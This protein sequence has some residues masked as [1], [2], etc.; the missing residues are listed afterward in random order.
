M[1]LPRPSDGWSVPQCDGDCR[2]KGLSWWGHSEIRPRAKLDNG[3]LVSSNSCMFPSGE[4][5]KA[6]TTNTI[7]EHCHLNYY[8]RNQTKS[9]SCLRILA[10][11][12]IG[13]CSFAKSYRGLLK[14]DPEETRRLSTDITHRLVPHNITSQ[15]LV[16]A[17]CAVIWTFIL[18]N[19]VK[20]SRYQLTLHHRNKRTLGLKAEGIVYTGKST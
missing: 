15:G 19:C 8:L 17:G 11:F 4:H 14:K 10:S 2:V 5:I 18:S 6:T 3:T 1:D 13:L 7:L 20:M 12:P 16:D 9:Q